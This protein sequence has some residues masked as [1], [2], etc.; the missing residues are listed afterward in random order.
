MLC[1]S[2]HKDYHKAWISRQKSGAI[3]WVNIEMKQAALLQRYPL[4]NQP[5]T[6]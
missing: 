6:P 2:T 1:V 5:D 4:K 3:P